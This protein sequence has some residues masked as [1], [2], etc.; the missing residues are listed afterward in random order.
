MFFEDAPVEVFLLA[1]GCMDGESLG[2]MCH[3]LVR[4]LFR[5]D[6]LQCVYPAVTHSVGELFLLPP[7][8]LLGEH[9]GKGFSQYLLLHHISGAH[10]GLRV[11]SHGYVQEVAVQEGDTSLHTPGG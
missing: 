3:L 5:G 2:G 1:Q 7:C 4:Y 11:E 8:Y 6:L 9:V 10:L